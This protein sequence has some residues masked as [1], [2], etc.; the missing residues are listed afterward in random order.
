MGIISQCPDGD[1]NMCVMP[2]CSHLCRKRPA[3]GHG[4]APRPRAVREE[5]ELHRPGRPKAGTGRPRSSLRREP[6]ERACRQAE[7]LWTDRKAGA[8]DGK[9]TGPADTGA[10]KDRSD[11][12]KWR[13]GRSNKKGTARM[14]VP[15]SISPRPGRCCGVCGGASLLPLPREGQAWRAVPGYG[16]APPGAWPP[17]AAA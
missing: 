12:G 16:R 6:H 17:G 4:K 14:A 13:S 9:R 5:R 11:P 15:Q 8:G 1:G 7:D 2:S 3:P 10:G